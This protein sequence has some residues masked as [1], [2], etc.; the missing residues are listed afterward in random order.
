MAL[1]IGF[2][3]GLIHNQKSLEKRVVEYKQIL[4]DNNEAFRKAI[5]EL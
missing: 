2:W 1:G 4:Q 3:N 5:D